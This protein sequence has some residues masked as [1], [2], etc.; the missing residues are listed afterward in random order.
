ML[1]LLLGSLT[2]SYI[3]F[4]HKSLPQFSLDRLFQQN[5]PTTAENPA[6]NTVEVNNNVKVKTVAQPSLTPIPKYPN[7]ATDEFPEVRN[8]N[9]VVG[10][11]PKSKPTPTA[12]TNQGT[13]ENS[14]NSVT[15]PKLQPTLGLDS[16][17]SSRATTSQDPSKTQQKPDTEIKPSADGFYHVVID[18]Q[19][20]RAFASARQVVPDAYLSADGKII[21]LGALKSKEQTQA[22]LQELQAKGVNARIK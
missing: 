4:N 18:N 22:L 20:D 11:K 9:D 19:G 7:L 13:A 6:D 15:I 21:Y 17:P 16:T 8:P 5:A 10:L 2:L 12:F 3:I 1:L 14:T